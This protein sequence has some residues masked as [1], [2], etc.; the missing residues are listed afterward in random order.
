MN[1]PTYGM[2]N[3][4]GKR[5]WGNDSPIAEAAAQGWPLTPAMLTTPAMAQVDI[6]A[7]RDFSCGDVPTLTKLWNQESGVVLAVP[8]KAARA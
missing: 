1:S 2:G 3:S 6:A 5:W 8:A 7:I 4:I